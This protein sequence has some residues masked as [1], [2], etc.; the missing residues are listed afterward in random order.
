MREKIVPEIIHALLGL[1]D[2]G[3]FV[4]ELR[5]QLRLVHKT[6]LDNAPNRRNRLFFIIINLRIGT[7]YVKVF[8]MISKT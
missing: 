4:L 3:V 5:P 1:D 6:L 7:H 8:S 2:P